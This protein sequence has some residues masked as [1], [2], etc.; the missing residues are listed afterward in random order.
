VIAISS[1]WRSRK[2]ISGK[3][4][5]AELKKLPTDSVELEFRIP[6]LLYEEMKPFL[7]N[8]DISVVSL[9][10]YFPVPD[11]L[12]PSEGSG[13]AFLLS[14]N[15]E[16]ERKLAIRY[17]KKTLQT[18]HSLGVENV[19]FHLGLVPMDQPKRIIMRSLVDEVLGNFTN[20][21]YP[22]QVKRE[23]ESRKGPYFDNCLKSLDELIEEAAKLR[24]NICLENR[25]YPTEMPNLEELTILFERYNGAPLRYW[26]D[27]GHGV[28]H[29]RL[30]F[31]R[32]LDLIQKNFH[33]MAGIHLHDV[34]GFRD[35]LAPSMGEIDFRE[36]KNHLPENIVQVMEIHEQATAAE[37]IDAFQL[38][39]DC[40]F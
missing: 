1:A 13:D 22:S 2:A 39:R 4:L 10:N 16:E 40:G 24:V 25:Y 34:K 26:H 12:M 30:G 17:S 9:H 11:V 14:S 3:G 21:D 8:E 5:I 23:R 35:H 31:D 15:D 20:Q 18:A 36:L 19:I 32:N 7:N 27:L 28:I 37:I 33:R 6:S 38:L 29:E